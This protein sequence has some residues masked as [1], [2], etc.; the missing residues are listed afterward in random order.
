MAGVYQNTF[1]IE[2]VA[3]LTPCAEDSI[4]YYGNNDDGDG[5]MEDQTP[6]ASNSNVML[7]PSNFSRPGYGFAGWNTELDGTGTT[8]GPSQT[9]AVGDLSEEGLQLY[10]KWV[11]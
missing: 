6:V 11:Q 4:C 2:I 10:A 3:N 5:E 9:I 8:Y 7:T 1:V